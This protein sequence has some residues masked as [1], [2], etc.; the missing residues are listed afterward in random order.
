MFQSLE[1]G[2]VEGQGVPQQEH[3]W[4]VQVVGHVGQQGGQVLLF[5]LQH[6]PYDL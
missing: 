5:Q 2:L 6:L 3:V 1:L 4:V